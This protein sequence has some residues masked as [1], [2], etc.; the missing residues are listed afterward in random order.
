MRRF[1]LFTFLIRSNG[2]LGPER[3]HTSQFLS[4]SLVCRLEADTPGMDR[5]RTLTGLHSEHL[6]LHLLDNGF[7]QFCKYLAGTQIAKKRTLSLN[8]PLWLLKP[9]GVCTNSDS[10]S[11]D[12]PSRRVQSEAGNISIRSS[13]TWMLILR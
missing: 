12:S 2:G 4:L 11:R 6:D 1:A 10:E 7:R 13:D 9:S 5:G 3:W 8:S